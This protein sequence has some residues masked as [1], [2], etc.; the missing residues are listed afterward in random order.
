[1]R[2]ALARLEQHIICRS[3]IP[4][5][6]SPSAF[7]NSRNGQGAILLPSYML[8]RARSQFIYSLRRSE[9]GMIIS[10]SLVRAVF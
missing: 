5:S 6:V 4:P 9:E 1:M 10:T 7:C 8:L 3:F 2:F